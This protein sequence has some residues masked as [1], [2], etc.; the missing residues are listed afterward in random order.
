[1]PS[2]GYCSTSATDSSFRNLWVC[3]ACGKFGCE[4]EKHMERHCTSN[5]ITSPLPHYLSFNLESFDVWCF[6]CKI[7]VQHNEW[8]GQADIVKKFIDDI[9]SFQKRSTPGKTGTSKKAIEDKDEEHAKVV[10]ENRHSERKSTVKI[11]STHDVYV[12]GL[13][14]LGNTCFF[15]SVLQCIMHTP[16]LL[17]FSQNVIKYE[18]IFIKESILKIHENEVKIPEAEIQLPNAKFL[19][20]KC[21]NGFLA[22]FRSNQDPNPRSLFHQISQAVPR[23]RGY[24]QQDAH[25]LLRYLLDVLRKEEQ[26]RW[27]QGIAMYLGLSVDTNP[28]KV[29]HEK[30]LLAKGLLE[31]AGRPLIDSIFGGSLLQSIRCLRCNHVSNRLEPYL[32]LSLPLATGT[33]NHVPNIKKK[34]V[35]QTKHQLKKQRK[36]QKKLPKGRRRTS[37]GKSISE[38]DETELNEL[39]ECDENNENNAKIADSEV[40][41]EEFIEDEEVDSLTSEMSHLMNGCA[42]AVDYTE[43]L[44]PTKMAESDTEGSLYRC[45]HDFIT[46]EFLTGLNAYECE[47]CCVDKKK[48]SPESSVRQ[49]VDASKRYV[50]YSPPTILTIHF[51][52]FEQCHSTATR[53]TFKKVRGHV[54]FPLKLDLASFCSRYNTRIASNQ[55]HIWYSLYGIVSHSGDLNNGHY[56]AYVRRRPTM[57]HH[58]TFI[59]LS[60]NPDRLNTNDSIHSFPMKATELNEHAESYLKT[61]EES[62]QWYYVSDQSVSLVQESRVLATEA[63]ILFYERVS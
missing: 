54:Q 31:A 50:I 17:T 58:N 23:F 53:T 30:V 47:K 33:K 49:K 12:K 7:K 36:Q 5:E 9:R 29:E 10:I 22:E 48:K 39:S 61:V 25:E 19:I 2:C 62:S 15:N 44:N 46:E 6:S 8:L 18:K 55:K 28:K 24:N 34:G 21:L 57:P 27:K 1:M 4:Q 14:N 60:K 16:Q 52:R 32:D 43:L 35:N 26:D 11:K 37:T 20:T 38:Q 45:L 41:H 42:P 56:V 13:P 40:F 51:K 3:M 59:E 63:Y